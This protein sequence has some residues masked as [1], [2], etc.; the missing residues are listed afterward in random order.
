MLSAEAALKFACSLLLVV[1]SSACGASDHAAPRLETTVAESCLIG[2]RVSPPSATLQ[3]GDS[4]RAKATYG[5]A[6]ERALVLWRSSDTSVATVGLVS[7]MIHARA[8]LGTATIIAVRVADTV[9]KGAMAL[10]TI[11]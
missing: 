8:A 10:Q 4:L 2:M 5:C 1:L 6:G 3:V 9:E 11:R 7:G